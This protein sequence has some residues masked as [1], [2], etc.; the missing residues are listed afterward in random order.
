MVNQR[1]S[2]ERK[3]FITFMVLPHNSTREVFRLN[4]PTWLGAVL[5]VFLVVLAVTVLGFFLYSSYV[6]GRLVH[7]YALQSENRAQAAQIKTFYSKTKELE[8]GIREL[9]ER[10]QELREILGLKKIP[11]RKPAENAQSN[12]LSEAISQR[13]ASINERMENRKYEL[14][15]LRDLSTAVASRFN[16][17]PSEWPVQGS[18]RSNFGFRIHPFTGKSTFHAGVDIPSWEGNRVRA[19]A[20]G[21]VHY[22]GWA[23][24]YGN[25]VIIDHPS[26]YR[27]IYGHN[28]RNIVSRGERIKKGQVVAVVGSTGLSTAAHVHYEIQHKS[29]PINPEPFLNLDIR[30]ASRILQ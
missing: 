4:L 1:E 27:T 13:L 19:T 18:I 12:N 23:N 21:I 17:Y 14:S 28:Q 22:S 10:D 30:M 25:V 16:G 15:A 3:K 26:G 6:T 24:G 29:R 2:T 9:E 8:T 11:A 20:D 5:A 7:Y